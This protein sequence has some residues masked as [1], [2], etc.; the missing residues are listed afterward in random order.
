MHV[1]DQEETQKRGRASGDVETKVI[2]FLYEEL[3]KRNRFLNY[4]LFCGIFHSFFSWD[5]HLRS[6]QETA[7]ESSSES[8]SLGVQLGCTCGSQGTSV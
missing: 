6:R 1:G 5:C 2:A 4:V 7:R 3:Q 8:D